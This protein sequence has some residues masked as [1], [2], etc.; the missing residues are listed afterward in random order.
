MEFDLREVLETFKQSR[1][2]ESYEDQVIHGDVVTVNQRIPYTL[3][4]V[5]DAG[6]KV[7]ELGP[8]GCLP[9]YAWYRG[10]NQSVSCGIETRAGIE[11]GT[12]IV[13][14]KLFDVDN[15]EQLLHCLVAPLFHGNLS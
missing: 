13:R 11:A 6:D 14:F 4:E 15:Q 1:D 8:A 5:M 3:L 7:H 10:D 9:F 2:T 12:T